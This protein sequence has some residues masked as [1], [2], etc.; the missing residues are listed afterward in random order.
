MDGPWVY[1]AIVNN[2]WSFAG[3]S[4][5]GGIGNA[6]NNFLLQPFVNYNFGEGWYVNT[7]PIMTS[8]W[9][10][11]AGQQWVVPVGA[12]IGRVI[13][14]FDKLPINL[15]LGA[16]YNAVHPSQT[17]PSWQLRSQLTFIF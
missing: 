17:G 12:G 11:P 1:G 4:G 8:N 2:V 6:Y 10:A 9:L 3:T 5:P 15:Q 16:Y 13:K 7:G 14:L